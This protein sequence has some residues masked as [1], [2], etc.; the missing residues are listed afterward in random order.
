[1]IPMSFQLRERYGTWA[2]VTG[3]SSG[4]GCRFAREL[5][6][7]GMNLVLI[8]RR[9]CLLEKLR[10][11]LVEKHGIEVRC[12]KVDLSADD[13]LT[14]VAD[15]CEDLE[16]GMIVLSAG[17]GVPGPFV[18]CDMEA[19]KRILILN[20]LAPVEMTR[21]FLPGMYE[22]GKGA[23]L[24][25]SSLMGFQGVPYMANYS[26]TKGYLL[27]FGEALHHECKAGGVDVLVVAPGATET[28]GAH[29]HEVDYS[30]LPLS[31]MSAEEV[32][33]AALKQIGKKVFVIPGV[34]NHLTACLS[35]GLWSRGFVQRI[36]KRLARHALASKLVK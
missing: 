32:V 28:P 22:R 8:A 10:E 14:T 16:I 5:A 12:V 33:D 15:A 34:R 7:E 13:A 17:T 18:E 25:V 30:K 26:A 24:M 9:I 20:G 23:I 1:M 31:W 21:W 19:E 11:E 2:L 27:N 29:L 3:A 6:A 4:I 35:G 36:M